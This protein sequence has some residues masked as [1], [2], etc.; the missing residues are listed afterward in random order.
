MSAASPVERIAASHAAQAARF[1]GGAAW[2]ERRAAALGRLASRG[3]PDRRDENWKY[4]DHALLT[5]ANFDAPPVARVTPATLAPLLL[6][7]A[8]ARRIVLQDGR[9]EPALSELGARDGIDVADLADLLARDPAGSLGLLREPGDDADDRYALLAD[10]FAG[11]GLAIRAEPGSAPARP[12]ELVHVAT[13][14]APAAHHA[15]LVVEL[16][17]GARLTLIE[18]F[19]SAGDAAVLGNL[20]AEVTI[21]AGAVLTHVRLHR[22]GG[23]AAQVETW[24]ARVDREGRLDQHLV[25]LGGR[26]L[27]SNLRVALDGHAAECRLSGL[28]LVNGLR[29]ADLLTRIDHH[30]PATRTRQDYRAIAT[31]RGR[32]A[33]NGR[34]VVHP[35]AA[36]A[37]AAQSSRNLLLSPLA[38]INTRPQLEIH[39]DDVQCRHGATTG[40][41]DP[42]QFFYL[43]SRGLGPDAARAVLTQAFCADLLAGLP[44][45]EPREAVIRAVSAGLPDQ[46]LA[47]SAA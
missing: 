13:A 46:E 17:P 42:E 15:R 23:Q 35:A 34:I 7:V 14:T 45:P 26:L 10:A 27:R 21:G 18:Q 6:P 12:L 3:L 29:Q 37:D 43:L 38:E 9:C 24:V 41:L 36:G 47:G 32:A 40:T 25:V 16:A 11:T 30:G 20:A 19:V 31:G 2:S 33:L 28:A 8:G 5:G 39:V 1:S 4:L 22:Q 44:G